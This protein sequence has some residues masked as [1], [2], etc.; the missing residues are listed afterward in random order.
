MSNNRSVSP[1]FPEQQPDQIKKIRDEHTRRL[2][3]AFVPL[4]IA[5]LALPLLPINQPLASPQAE[6]GL[7]QRDQRLL[8]LAAKKL[9]VEISDLELLNST[10]VNLPLTRREVAA[11]KIFRRDR[12]EVVSI[13][14]D[15]SDNEVDLPSLRRAEE[16]AHNARYGKLDPF[17]HDKAQAMRG[18]DKVKVAFW[19]K[20]QEDLDTQDVREGRTDLTAEEVESLIARREEQLRKATANATGPLKSALGK[21]GFAIDEV[22]LTAPVVYATVPVKALSALAQRADVR[23]IYAAD[24]L[25]EDYLNT[26]AEA[27]Y[28]NYVWDWYGFT[29]TG[30]RV[31]IVEDSRVDFDNNCLVNNLGTRV[32]GDA[33]VDQHA[34]TTAG[35]VASN[36]ATYRGIAF[37]AGIYSANGTSYDDDDMA[38]ALDA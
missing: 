34:T 24:N 23:K 3:S 22:S 36:H 31:A 9:G 7:S 26:A 8:E 2:R 28:A 15:S 21:S 25:N 35:M 38:A 29:G 4:L 33:N 6:R 16:K 32:P 19:L 30:A 11:G 13:S 18:T 14:I 12:D 37:G 17:L 10:T 5:T 27:V 1:K 20:H